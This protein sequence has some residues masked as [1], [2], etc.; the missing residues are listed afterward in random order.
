MI[1]LTNELT[2]TLASRISDHRIGGPVRVWCLQ[3]TKIQWSTLVR[4]R[5][6]SITY[7]HKLRDLTLYTVTSVS[8]FSI[9][10]SIH[11]SRAS[12]VDD[13]FLYFILT[14][15]GNNSAVIF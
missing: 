9:L 7:T 4:N 12:L 3:G 14:T 13:Y 6:F 5:D 2:P 10:F 1:V 11:R 15:L 8:L